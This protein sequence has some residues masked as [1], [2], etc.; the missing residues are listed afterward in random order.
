VF[1]L[2]SFSPAVQRGITFLPILGDLRNPQRMVV[3]V[4]VV[5]GIAAAVGLDRLTRWLLH[6]PQ[7]ASPGPHEPRRSGTSG[8]EPGPREPRE[9]R[10]GGASGWS[11]NA[12][13]RASLGVLTAIVIGNLIFVNTETLAGIFVITTPLKQDHAFRQGWAQQRFVGTEDSFPFTMKNTALNQGSVNR[14]SVASVR[15]SGALRIPPEDRPNEVGREFTDEPYQGE[16]F[17]LEGRAT[18]TVETFR[19]SEVAVRYSAETPAI[20]ALNQNYHPGWSVRDL[21]K[22]NGEVNVLPAFGKRDLVAAEIGPG[23]GTAVFSYTPSFLGLGLLTSAVGLG[24]ALWLW[25]R[26]ELEPP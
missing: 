26:K 23:S 15:P 16:A 17:V 24:T 8:W 14:C 20:L 1:L 18:A 25:K 12:A 22:G 21:G 6:D 4:T 19:T 10:Q 3:M 9:P 13:V 7:S 2:G 11:S 5:V